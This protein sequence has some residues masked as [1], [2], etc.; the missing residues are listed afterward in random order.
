MPGAGQVINYNR[1]LYA[2]GNPLKYTDPAGMRRPRQSEN[3]RKRTVGTTPT[4]GFGAVVI[5][6]LKALLSSRPSKTLETYW[7]QP[8]SNQIIIFQTMN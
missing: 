6:A 7:R 1:F 4:A 3:G 5:G 8:E 2:R